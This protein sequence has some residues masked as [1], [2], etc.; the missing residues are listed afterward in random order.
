MAKRPV[1]AAD[2]Q[3]GMPGCESVERGRSG[4]SLSPEALVALRRIV[5][6][7]IAGR[8]VI[9]TRHL[10]DKFGREIWEELAAD[11]LLREGMYECH[12]LTPKAVEVAMGWR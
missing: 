3:P 4:S 7:N 1:R 11:G 8:D 6:W 9:R 10:D 5:A 12:S 2:D